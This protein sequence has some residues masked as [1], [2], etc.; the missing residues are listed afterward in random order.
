M[1]TVVRF[2]ANLFKCIWIFLASF[3]SVVVMYVL[4]ISVEQGIDV[5]IHAGEYPERGIL[6]LAA[7]ILWAYLLWYSSRTLSYVRQDKDDRQFLESYGLYTIPTKFY[8][9]IPRFLAYN[10]FV[11]GQTAI[12]NLPTIYAWNVWLVI[13]F[14]ALHGALYALLHLYLTGNKPRKTKYG[15]AC[16]FIIIC[17]GGFIVVDAVACGN[18]L[19]MR[20]FSNDPDRHEFWLR[21][22][23]IVLFV[24]QLTCVAFFIRRRKKIDAML[25]ANREA[26]GYY[27]RDSRTSDPNKKQIKKWFQHPRFSHPES[28]YFKTFNAISMVAAAL[29]LGAVFNISF[30]TYMGPLALA[31]L[32]FGILTGLAN[33]IQVTSIRLGFSV[34]FILYLIAFFVGYVFRDPYQVRLRKDGPQKHFANRPTPRAYLASW[35]DKRL[36][37]ISL[38]ERYAFG[39]DKFP[40]YIVLSN[41]GASRAGKWTTGVLSH[42]QDVSRKRN[43]QDKFSDHILAIAGASGGSVGNC[44][45]YSLLKAELSND[46]LF[47]DLGNY[48]AHSNIFFHSDFLTFTLSRFLGPDLIRHLVPIDMDDRAAALESLLSRSRD[49]L[50]NKYFDADVTEVF[51]YTGALPI[52]YIT[53]TK[54]DDGMPGLISTVQLSTTSKR[55]DILNI[56]DSIQVENERLNLKLSTAAILSSR[57]PYVSPAGKINKNYYVDGGY[58]DNSGAGTV[59]ELL[60]EMNEIF[61][62]S[63]KYRDKFSFH[64]LH[65]SNAE[66]LPKPTKDIH[67]LTNDLFAPLL[68][69][70]GMQGASTSISNGVLTR[71][72]LLFTKDTVNSL[73]EYNLYDKFYS[74]GE[75]NKKYEEGYPMSWVISDYQ[76]DRMDSALRR[77][78]LQNMKM[79]Y[80]Y[81]PQLDGKPVH[82][83]SICCSWREAL[84]MSARE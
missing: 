77:A 41:G 34:F 28:E 65:N 59:L 64:I 38:N 42:L 78:N 66:V 81:D 21:I 31:I 55:N 79:F 1:R 46:P 4:L 14:V 47:K 12:L 15:I 61:E 50:L 57:F 7:F 74:P 83:R 72:F 6:A 8:Q 75:H 53:S 10:C 70:A 30:S 35:L 3:V 26:P 27:T 67:P 29:Y 48:S 37:Q 52:L 16:L 33:F 20:V 84:N 58:F 2:L 49:P 56:I 23:L 82:K 69:L 13:A 71:N 24:L 18:D 5:V 63:A 43:P 40:V 68:T 60:G 25:A 17:Y 62:D 80:F 76:I 45:F 73:V 44:V 22:I 9:H 39:K 19:G 54:V 32:A 51:D 36:E 11:C